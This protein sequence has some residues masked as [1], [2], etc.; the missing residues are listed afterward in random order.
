[1]VSVRPEIREGRA[2]GR[3]TLKTICEFVEPIVLAAWMTPGSTSLRAVSTILATNGAAAMESGTIVDFV[4]IAVPTI[5]L[6]RGNR[7]MIR[8]MK[9]ND[10][11]MFTILLRI[12]FRTGFGL[13]PP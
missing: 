8:M 13:I 7:T 5:I 10:L 6:E 4:P 3:R 9:G 1:M 2:S 12:S 11:R